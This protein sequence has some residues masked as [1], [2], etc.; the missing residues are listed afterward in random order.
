MIRSLSTIH[1]FV[2]NSDI[3]DQASTIG[4]SLPDGYVDPRSLSLSSDAKLKGA[5]TLYSM[6]KA[7]GQVPDFYIIVTAESGYIFGRTYSNIE[8]MDYKIFHEPF[9]D[10]LSR[11]AG[12]GYNGRLAESCRPSANGGERRVGKENVILLSSDG[13]YT[14]MRYF[15]YEE[16]EK[17]FDY[18]HSLGGKAR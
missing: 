14:K 5:D 11:I 8:R 13:R 6:I 4:G 18:I 7:V 9:D 1:D 17:T 15:Q 10:S 12:T 16:G 3:D 2:A